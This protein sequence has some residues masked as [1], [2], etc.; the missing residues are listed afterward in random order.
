MW[1][2]QLFAF[3]VDNSQNLFSLIKLERWFYSI[4]IHLFSVTC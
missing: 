1:D 3:F 2:F 4:Y